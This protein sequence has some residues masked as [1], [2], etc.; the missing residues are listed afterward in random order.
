MTQG[1]ICC[2]INSIASCINISFLCT[3][4]RA[5]DLK[6]IEDNSIPQILIYYALCWYAWR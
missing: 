1:E 2:I 4:V 3:F 5:L 6:I